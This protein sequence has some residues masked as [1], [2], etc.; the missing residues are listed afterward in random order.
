MVGARRPSTVTDTLED[1]PTRTTAPQSDY[2]QRQV[3]IG[4]IVLA[5]GLAIAYLAP[6]LL[7]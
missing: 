4:A 2:S 3:A 1:A 5:V 7:F 6:G